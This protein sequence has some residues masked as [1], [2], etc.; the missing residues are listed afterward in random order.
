MNAEVWVM[1]IFAIGILVA[2]AVS[3]LTL[4]LRQVKDGDISWW[5]PPGARAVPRD[6]PRR[7]EQADEVRASG[8]RGRSR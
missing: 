4:V 8:A 3:L 5:S 7:T 2:L 6:E 1:V